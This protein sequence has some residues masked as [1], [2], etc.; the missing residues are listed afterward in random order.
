MGGYESMITAETR[1]ILVEAAWFDPASVRRSARRH[2]L[3]TDASHRFE[4]G[5]DFNAAPTANN[6]VSKLILAS[7]GHLEGNLIDIVVPDIADRTAAR[8]AIALSVKQVQ[9]HLGTTLAPEGITREIVAP[10][11][12][13]PRL[14]PRP[15]FGGY[16][17][18]RSSQ[19]A[20]R[21]RT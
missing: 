17:R 4:R 18:S 19:L 7:G 10:I 1:N 6:L 2:G 9:R 13:L 14:H 3:H 8:P 21:P 20:P 5:A 11:P 15:P 16:L 12:H